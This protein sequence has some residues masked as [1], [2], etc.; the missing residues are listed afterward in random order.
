MNWC[1]DPEG[2]L[3]GTGHVP[4]T[5]SSEERQTNSF[6]PVLQQERLRSIGEE[7]ILSSQA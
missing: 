4:V 5:Q 1:K 2:M 3:E 7:N 6:N